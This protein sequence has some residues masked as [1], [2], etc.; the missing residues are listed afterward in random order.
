MVGN[1]RTP[2]A[3]R[4]PARFEPHAYDPKRGSANELRDM[5]GYGTVQAAER[6]LDQANDQQ[7]RKAAVSHQSKSRAPQHNPD[8]THARDRRGFGFV[9]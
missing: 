1:D 6:P 4:R 2:V 3:H 5:W 9:V 7:E 8:P